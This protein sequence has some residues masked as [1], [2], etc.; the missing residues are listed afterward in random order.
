MTS[1]IIIPGSVSESNKMAEV[2]AGGMK[3]MVGRRMVKKVKF[4]GE[5]LEISKLSVA[6]VM[7]IQTKAK[8]LEEASKD[9]NSDHNGEDDGL[10]LLQG[11][12]RAS[13]ESAK[14]LT[15][16]EFATFPMDELSKLSSAI[17]EFSG[18]G[19]NQGK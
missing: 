16:D 19:G 18:I 4:M 7:D 8:E 14:E 10:N 15:D 5:D 13:V 11:V 1:H 17:M 3:G 9:E 12:I 2:K 6:E